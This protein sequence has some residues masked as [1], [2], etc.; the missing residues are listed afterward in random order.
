MGEFHLRLVRAEG[1]AIDL[2]AREVVRPDG[3]AR[4]GLLAPYAPR[5][6]G[7]QKTINALRGKGEVVIVD[8]PGH[9]GSRRELGCDRKLVCRGGKWLV[10]KLK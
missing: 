3:A 4:P 9:A 5:D 10:A 6:S 1:A 2:S 8:L 7:L